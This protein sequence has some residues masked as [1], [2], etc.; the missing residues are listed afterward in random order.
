[1]SESVCGKVIFNYSLLLLFS[2]Y[3]H[4]P[5]LIAHL[6]L[7]EGLVVLQFE[8][9]NCLCLHSYIKSVPASSVQ[10]LPFIL[11]VIEEH[12]EYFWVIAEH[13]QMAEK[14]RSVDPQ[15][16]LQLY[17]KLSGKRFGQEDAAKTKN[18]PIRKLYVHFPFCI[19]LP[20]CL[21]F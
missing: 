11:R 20:V 19:L 2:K 6:H 8:I 7:R 3:S 5:A 14:S 1:M 17:F 21:N 15:N 18:K 9:V 16:F 4:S 10:N 12:F 13:F